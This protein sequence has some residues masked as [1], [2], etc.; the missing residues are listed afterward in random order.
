MVCSVCGSAGPE[1]FALVQEGKLP[2]CKRDIGSFI[3]THGGLRSST[4]LPISA[5]GIV[6]SV[7]DLQVYDE[8][9]GEMD[10]GSRK[11]EK[12]LAV[13][14]DQ[15]EKANLALLKMKED[16]ISLIDIRFDKLLQRFKNFHQVIIDELISSR[17]QITSLR[18]RGY[19][20]VTQEILRDN[21]EKEPNFY[22]ELI[23]DVTKKMEK[24]VDEVLLL[25]YSSGE[26]F[27][28][29]VLRPDSLE[30]LDTDMC[31]SENQPPEHPNTSIMS[32]TTPKSQLLRIIPVAEPIPRKCIKCTTECKR[33]FHACRDD[34]M[35]LECY[36]RL[37]ATECYSMKK[38][39]CPL[40]GK[41]PAELYDIREKKKCMM[42]KF[43]LKL[44][45][46]AHWCPGSD[47]CICDA[48]Y[49][50][51]Y[52]DGKCVKC[53]QLILPPPR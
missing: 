41:V 25:E 40:C 45:E 51:I 47:C 43:R 10:T 21:S 48:C 23:T 53:S 6:E 8:K 29:E 22:T 39:S 9:V 38:A 32:I 19:S 17:K 4:I 34:A 26:D 7:A 50:K 28:L 18:H 42:C 35:C 46:I 11:V 16:A 15:F 37:I 1:L 5:F 3:E 24:L 31:S 14:T 2:I 36:E 49:P 27:M 33:Q 13:E 20:K 52:S 44:T 30:S 12:L